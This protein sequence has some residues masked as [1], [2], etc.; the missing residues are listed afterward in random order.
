MKVEGER[1]RSFDPLQQPSVPVGKDR[2]SADGAV[3]VKPNFSLR[4]KSVAD[5]ERGRATGAIQ[6]PTTRRVVQ[7][8][9]LAAGDSWK[10]IESP[11][12]GA[13]CAYGGWGRRADGG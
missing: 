9:S 10:R 2:S 8:A 12:E 4:A 7:T 5:A 3:D 6:V 13:H 11:A 1:I